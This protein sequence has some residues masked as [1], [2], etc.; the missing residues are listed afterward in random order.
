MKIDE[1]Q[2]VCFIGAG[3]MGCY[4]AIWAA[5]SGYDV[6]LYDISAETLDKAPQRC[7]DMAGYLAGAGYCS[8]AD[9]PAAQQRISLVADLA[10]ATANAD[11]VSESV[12]E[13]VDVKREV[14]AQLDS[15][16][17][18]HTILTTNSST[19]LVSDIQDVVQRSDRFAALHFHMASP[20]VDIVPGPQAST[21]VVD[22]LER[23]VHSLKGSPLVLK[24][25]YPG[26]VLNAVLGAVLTT[27]QAM[28]VEGVAS[29]EDVDRAWMSSRTALIGPFGLL[30]LFGLNLIYDKWQ[31]R[32]DDGP[33]PGLRGGALDL[34]RPY[35]ERGEL[36]MQSGKGFYRYPEPEYQ[37]FGFL[38]SQADLA[39]I[40]EP[41]TMALVAGAVLVAAAGVAEPEDIDR[42]WT[43]G[44]S[45]STGP[46]E[47]LQQVG[48]A[49]FLQRFARHVDSGWFD[50]GRAANVTAFVE[51]L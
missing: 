44:V 35:V 12:F 36:G 15:V 24:K 10:Q 2:T 7:L 31:H 21:A 48:A 26:Y 41:L 39:S 38:A 1:I 51:T 9:I 50:A 14:H 25:E 4:N 13:R 19:L 17:P 43:V 8:V 30:D 47:I 49:E 28:V 37:Q 27:A 3:S 34:L 22:I 33:I 46:F 23:Y 11:L 45:L 29:P 20:L 32:D 6:V 18:A 16:C 5:V 42:A 40:A